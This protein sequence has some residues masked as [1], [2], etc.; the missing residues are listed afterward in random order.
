MIFCGVDGGGT[1]T[2]IILSKN[3]EILDQIIVGPSSIDT[4][5]IDEMYTIVNDGLGELVQRNNNILIDSIFLGLGGIASEEHVMLVNMKIKESKHLSK[6]CKVDSS[7]DIQNAYMVSCDGRN[8]ITLIIGTGAVA[9]GIDEQGKKHRTNGIHFKEGDFGSGYDIGVRILTRM[10]KAFDGRI[11]HTEI[12][13]HLIS[14]FSINT[15]IDLVVFFDKYKHNRTFV[16]NLAR[17]IVEFANKNDEYALA[18]LEEGAKEIA[19]SVIG[20]DCK[21]NL[22]NREVGIIGGLGSATIYFDMIE[23]YIKEYDL[24]IWVHTSKRDPVEGS[25]QLAKLL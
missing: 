10:S 5:S 6:N 15:F 1:K 11:K 14:K 25:L 4:V 2:K 19:L 23:K 20:V 8:N 18:V 16:A 24:R 7:N 22:K 21:I 12:T 9:Y 17:T 3:D 13:K